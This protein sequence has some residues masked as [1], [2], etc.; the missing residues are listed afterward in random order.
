MQ[1]LPELPQQLR[2]AQRAVACASVQ[3]VALDQVIQAVAAL[4]GL[5]VAWNRLRRGSL[6][7]GF[8]LG[9]Q[10]FWYFVVG[11]WP[12]IYLRVYF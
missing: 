12:V 8:F 6:T 3:P 4:I 5:G 2:I 1:P 9:A 11:V 10:T 7:P